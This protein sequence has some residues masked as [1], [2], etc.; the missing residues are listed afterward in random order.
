MNHL[1]LHEFESE[2]RYKDL[3][4]NAHDLIQIT[5][6]D[7]TLLYVNR[8]WTNSLEYS[9]EEIQGKSFFSFLDEADI[10]HFKN[11]RSRIIHSLE[12][13]SQIT[14]SIKTKTGKKITV[15]GFVSAKIKDGNPIY[16]RGIFRDI[17]SK[18]RNEEKLK[19]SNEKLIER[20]YNLQ[21][22]LL[23]APDAIVVIDADSKIMFWN[24]KAKQ[25]FGWTK[26]EV[27]GT[28]FVDK[29]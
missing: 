3:F 28:S 4:D 20:E 2:E 5:A 18:I 29:I 10:E 1:P 22:L 14:I 12:T 23:Y 13:S 27:H 16:T 19:L 15:E 24:P 6:L 26:E 9:Q 21:Q 7:G 25:L 17:T 8:S 11:Y